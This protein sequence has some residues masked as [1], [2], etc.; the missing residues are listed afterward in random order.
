MKREALAA[1]A[2]VLVASML[3]IGYAGGVSNRQTLTA[4][5]VVTS[6]TTA[7]SVSMTTATSISTYTATTLSTLTITA[8]ST[9]TVT[10]TSTLVG[11]PMSACDNPDY[12][13]LPVLGSNGFGA[14]LMQPDSTGYVCV[15]YHLSSDYNQTLQQEQ[16]VLNVGGVWSVPA[17][18]NLSIVKAGG[19]QITVVSAMPTSTNDTVVYAIHAAGNSTGA[20]T[21]WA[22]GTCPGYALVVGSNATAYAPA[23]KEYYEG[24]FECPGFM[25]AGR[26]VGVLG[27]AVQ[28][29]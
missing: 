1:L 20:Y 21:W 15:F 11:S 8:T 26:L 18:D 13:G 16:A 27:I 9:S 6:T 5:S 19:I 28:P 29:L 12:S 4:T 24:Q 17:L 3:A 10:S 23:F 22:P 14:M 2:A 25:M 7:T